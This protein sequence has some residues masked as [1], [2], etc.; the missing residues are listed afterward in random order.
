M[1]ILGIVVGIDKGNVLKGLL[2]GF[3]AFMV[4]YLLPLLVIELIKPKS[5]GIEL[6]TMYLTMATSGFL[7]AK[8]FGISLREIRPMLYGAVLGALFGTFFHL[9]GFEKFEKLEKLVDEKL[10]PDVKPRLSKRD[11]N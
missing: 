5:E 10:Q 2:F 6:V 9:G 4:F 8:P 1:L 3:W 7:L 11:T